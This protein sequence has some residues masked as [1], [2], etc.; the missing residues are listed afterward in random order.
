VKK[1]VA[2]VLPGNLCIDAEK[3]VK[4]A[5]ARLATLE[6]A[7]GR[8]EDDARVLADPGLDEQQKLDR[9]EGDGGQSP[10]ERQIK[11]TESQLGQKQ[12]EQESLEEARASAAGWVV[13]QW[14][15]RG[16]GWAPSRHS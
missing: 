4:K 12:A 9:L 8:A 14:V 7:L 3:A 10:I 16:S 15:G 13:N 2:W 11:S 6:G 1:V 5:E